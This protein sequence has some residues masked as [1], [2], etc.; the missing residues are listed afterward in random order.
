MGE[1]VRGDGR[2]IGVGQGEV[3]ATL[4]RWWR[5]LLGGAM[6]AWLH[7]VLV[8]F[9]FLLPFP[10]FGPDG[11]NI[12]LYFLLGAWLLNR[13]GGR[14]LTSDQTR[15]AW[16][17]LVYLVVAGL[18]IAVSSDIALS[19]RDFQRGPLNGLILFLILAEERG[20]VARLRH[21]FMAL[22]C[23]TTLVTGYGIFGL[24][25]GRVQLDGM[26]TSVYGWKNELGYV[27]AI[28]VT[29]VVWELLGTQHAARRSSW[30]ILGLIQL[31]VLLMSYTRAALVAVVMAYCVL[32]VG[33]RRFSLLPIGAVVVAGLLAVGGQQIALRYLSIAQPSTYLAGTL[34]G[35][36]ELWHG[37]VAMIRHRPLLGYG[38]GLALFPRTAQA[39]ARQTGDFRATT[40]SHAHN[41]FLE[42]MVETGLL[43]LVALC[44]LGGTV[45]RV[46]VKRCRGNRAGGESSKDV[47]VLLLALYAVVAGISLTDYLLADRFG[48]LLWT[49]FACTGALASERSEA[50]DLNSARRVSA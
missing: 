43:G 35:R 49:L 19:I 44:V 10:F 20:D 23:A 41:L 2:S 3:G 27:L 18:S 13:R 9:V 15:L 4:W 12:L 30:A 40:A 5:A 34:S 39:F 37:T 48:V 33:F 29:I 7:W 28:S 31:A 17:L 8:A 25:T 1:Q 22:I 11:R 32:A 14:R 26:L 36:Q 45:A 50:T 24:L 16:A 21:Y 47:A 38:F 6:D 46:L 42:V